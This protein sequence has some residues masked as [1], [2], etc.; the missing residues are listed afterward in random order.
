MR[1]HRPVLFLRWPRVLHDFLVQ[2]AT[3][4]DCSSERFGSLAEATSSVLKEL[5]RRKLRSFPLCLCIDDFVA[6]DSR[7]YRFLQ[8]LYHLPECSLIV[9]SRARSDLGHVAKLMWDPRETIELQPLQ[10]KDARL[11]LEN[12]IT[13]LDVKGN[14][15]DEFQRQ[16]IRKSGGN[17]GKILACCT[18]ASREQFR[19]QE[20]ILVGPLLMEAY[21]RF[22]P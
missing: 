3:D 21:A 15:I 20:S 18:L 11:L 5:I 1:I 13:T 12:A 17:P 8:D 9:V 19:R 22:L 16:V 10:A 2:L 7:T 14:N 6:S 4:L